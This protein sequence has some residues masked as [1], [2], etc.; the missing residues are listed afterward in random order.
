MDRVTVDT[1]IQQFERS[2]LGAAAGPV[3]PCHSVVAKL[4]E[5]IT[6]AQ[7]C[8]IAATL[9]SLPHRKSECFHGPSTQNPKISHSLLKNK[10]ATASHGFVK[11]AATGASQSDQQAA[12]QRVERVVKCGFPRSKLC[13]RLDASSRLTNLLGQSFDVTERLLLFWG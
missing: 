1:A 13:I 6:R 8:R 10:N 4:K 3:L 11:G 9:A 5:F 2:T 7:N 12:E